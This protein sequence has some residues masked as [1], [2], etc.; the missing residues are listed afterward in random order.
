MGLEFCKASRASIGMQ[1]FP[2]NSCQLASNVT[3]LCWWRQ[4]TP[5]VV[6]DAIL[7]RRLRSLTEALDENILVRNFG[8]DEGRGKVT[9][10]T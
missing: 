4:A 1:S 9:T 7:E 3:A 2:T 6:K 5:R 8:D 10:R